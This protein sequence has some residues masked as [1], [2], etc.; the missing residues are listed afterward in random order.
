MTCPNCKVFL[1]FDIDSGQGFCTNCGTKLLYDDE[2]PKVNFNYVNEAQALEDEMTD[3]GQTVY[4]KKYEIENKEFLDEYNKWELKT[5]KLKLYVL[6]WLLVVLSLAFLNIIPLM[7]FKFSIMSY[8][9]DLLRIPFLLSIIIAIVW[10]AK[11]Y[12][13]ENPSLKHQNNPEYEQFVKQYEVKKTLDEVEKEVEFQ[14]K[15]N[16]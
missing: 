7:L 11:L 2:K 5:I 16:I 6:G 13:F 3:A 12:F 4:R 1:D 10:G 14:K 9:S 8:F 15:H